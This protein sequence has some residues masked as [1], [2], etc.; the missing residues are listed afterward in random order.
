LERRAIYRDNKDR[1]D[2]LDL[3][4]EGAELWR[5]TIHGYVLMDNHFHLLVETGEPNLSRAMHWLNTSYIVWFNRRHGRAGPLFQ[6]V[7]K[8]ILVD[9]NGWGLMLSRYL[10]LN[11]VR[12]KQ[13]GLGKAAR[14]ADR[15]GVR[16][17]PARGLVQERI[18]H[19]RRYR[20]S[21]YRAYIGLAKRPAWLECDAVL[22]LNG[23]GAKVEQMK[24]YQR[25]V[26]EA[27]REGLQESPWEQVKGQL[28]LGPQQ[29]WE[30]LCKTIQAGKREQPQR[31]NLA[32]RPSFAEIISVVEDL[33]DERWEDI[34]DRRGDWGR[35]L[36]LYLGRR[37]SVMKLTELGCAIGGSDYAA[38]SVAIKR[39][40]GRLNTD[41]KL[42]QIV[43]RAHTRLTEQSIEC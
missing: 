18:E 39:F 19:L 23:K 10:H 36:A 25:Y 24:N 30:K 31:R 37:L 38:V 29:V 2:W 6:G 17:Q 16:G 34:R 3:L 20:W 28:F 11:P 22:E 12:A 7:Y 21:S 26:E 1:I 5:L 14:R 8:A 42:A 4:G 15:L 27:V 43:K 9:R 33:K 35:E 13:M 40:Q 41:K 32:R